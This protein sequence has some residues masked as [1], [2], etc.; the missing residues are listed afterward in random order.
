MSSCQQ[1]QN[2]EGNKK[3]LTQARKTPFGSILSMSISRFLMEVV[4]LSLH[5][6]SN[7]ST[8]YE[9]VNIYM[10]VF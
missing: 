9:F 10:P 6:H 5:Q 3:A 4:L 8:T 2:S 1:L 7:V